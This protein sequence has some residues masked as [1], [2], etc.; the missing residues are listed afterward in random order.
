[1]QPDSKKAPTVFDRLLFDDQ[2]KASSAGG[3]ILVLAMFGAA[4]IVGTL[5]YVIGHG[6]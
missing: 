3:A 1:M 6:L 5:L 2:G 4:G